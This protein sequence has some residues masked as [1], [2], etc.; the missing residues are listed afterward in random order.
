MDIL[1][2]RSTT[3]HPWARS[4]SIPTG[5]SD[6]WQRCFRNSSFR[7][8]PLTLPIGPYPTIPIVHLDA[9][10]PEA[11][12]SCRSGRY[13]SPLN[14]PATRLCSL[15][16]SIPPPRPPPGDDVSKIQGGW[17]KGNILQG[18]YADYTVKRGW[19][20][21]RVAFIDREPVQVLPAMEN[22][23]IVACRLFHFGNFF[24]LPECRARARRNFAAREI[25]REGFEF[26]RQQSGKL[27]GRHSSAHF[28][29]KKMG[30]ETALLIIH[31]HIQRCP[32]GN[33]L[34]IFQNLFA[35]QAEAQ[36]MPITD[37]QIY[38]CPSA[39]IVSSLP[40]AIT[41]SDREKRPSQSPD[42]RHATR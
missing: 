5:S 9:I 23:N 32:L 29:I 33:G 6:V 37:K 14:A 22:R 13:G 40:E 4:T 38:I 8:I 30:R 2:L 19:D 25:D 21:R 11:P 28:N 12:A 20:E 16:N 39:W 34:G 24:Q 7:F 31:R 17:K 35:D 41:Q 36:S 26:L 27:F 1:P 18:F 3:R 42:H 10:R 15:Y